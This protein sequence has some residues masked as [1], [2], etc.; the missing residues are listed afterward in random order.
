MLRSC[1]K[2]L[3]KTKW[4]SKLVRGSSADITQTE[5]PATAGW[6]HTPVGTETP[7]DSARLR[8]LAAPQCCV[9]LA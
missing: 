9:V 2:D 1:N 7:L 3:G 6:L 4:E 5:M 8:M